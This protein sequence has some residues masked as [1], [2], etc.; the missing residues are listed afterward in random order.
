[1]GFGVS[2]SRPSQT[3][4]SLRRIVVEVCSAVTNLFEPFLEPLNEEGVVHGQS[5]PGDRWTSVLLQGNDEDSISEGGDGPPYFL[6][7]NLNSDRCVVT[8]V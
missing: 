2:D 4:C 5:C 6:T 3:E 7:I 8:Q 1:M